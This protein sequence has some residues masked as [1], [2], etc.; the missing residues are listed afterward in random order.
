[1]ATEPDS[2]DF[3]LARAP[4]ATE[5]FRVFSTGTIDCFSRAVSLMARRC[6][7]SLILSPLLPGLA[8]FCGRVPVFLV[9]PLGA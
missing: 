6:G 8:S 4:G 2:K 7:R 1:M 9:S 5:L 3:E